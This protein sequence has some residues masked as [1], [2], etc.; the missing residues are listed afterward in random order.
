MGLANIL[1]WSGTVFYPFYVA[2]DRAHGISPITDQSLAGVVLMVQSALL[3]F[4]I[5]AW[6]VLRWARQDTERQE[7]LDLA[8]ER[9]I[10][11]DERR[12]GRAVAAGRAAELR[13]V[14]SGAEQAELKTAADRVPGPAGGGRRRGPRRVAAD[15]RVEPAC[16]RGSRPP[17]TG[18]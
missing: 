9:G 2:S 13:T 3:M 7:L 6:L 8:I 1:M 12:A 10:D 16:R 5:L 14:S 4:G 15:R 18:R 11:L 17:T